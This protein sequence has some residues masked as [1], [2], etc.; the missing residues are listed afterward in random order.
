M[1]SF[2]IPFNEPER[3]AAVQALSVSP[4]EEPILN[5]IV[6]MVRKELDVPTALVSIVDQDKQWFAARDGFPL[7]ET[8]RDYSICSHAILRSDPLVLCDTLADPRFRDHPVVVNPPHV[9]FYAGAPIVLSS[10]LRV[11]SLCALDYVPREQ[12]SA[13][14]LATLVGLS[15]VVAR[16]LE[17]PGRNATNTEA[18]QENAGRVAKSEFISLIGHELRTP[19]TI[20]LGSLKLL[21]GTDKASSA[22]SLFTS[23]LKATEHLQDLVERIIEFADA[24]TGE[25]RLNE[26]VCD[27][28]D[29]VASIA[30]LKLPGADGEAKSIR[31]SDQETS[32]KARVDSDQIRLALDALVINAV[33]HGGSE[34]LVGIGRDGDGNIELNVSDDGEM[35]DNVDLSFLDE[36]FVVG[37]RLDNRSTEGGLG[38][39]LPLTRKL[40]E[41]HGGEL[42]ISSSPGRT[43]AVIRLPAWREELVGSGP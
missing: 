43:S 20:A 2:P 24:S 10:G 40:V 21:E 35:N 17:R 39:G 29:I 33:Q 3:L 38:L 11:G 32:L 16:A 42:Q 14:S 37:G 41:L 9:R 15:H 6:D 25:L 4:D 23:A 12:P 28:T 34:I 30:E 7:C 13:S 1:R 18:R 27:L 19:L 8:S 5:E 31:R 26:Q 36:P 22:N